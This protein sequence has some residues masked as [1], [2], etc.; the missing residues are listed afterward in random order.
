MSVL[1]QGRESHGRQVCWLPMDRIVPNPHQ[2][3][4]GF[5]DFSLLELASSIRQHGLLQ[6][7][8]VREKAG[9]YEIIMGERRFRAC[10]LLGYTH[11]DAF[12]LAADRDESAVLAL[13]ENIQRE[14]LHY[15]EE[16]EAYADLL[17]QGMTQD[18]LAR[19]L[20]K[21]PSG[22]ANKLRLLK[23]DEKLRHFLFEEGLSERHARAL[24][25]LP[26]AA[27]RW[28]IARQAEAQRLTVR[29]TETLVLR[30]QKRLPVPPPGRK[31]IS[32]VRDHRLYINAIKSV[33][34]QMQDTGLEA[35]MDLDE[36]E[37][38]AEMRI[39]MGR[40]K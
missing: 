3:R 5:D 27:A 4:K 24:L 38:W 23:L 1:Q 30:A 14:N 12:V 39:R 29:E 11:I 28:R 22:V 36:G 9:Q 40:K 20:G 8:T 13:I 35:E 17:A 19:R 26:D 15:F 2:P 7:I 31:V 6:P 25:A 34:A 32:L 37:G 16:A 10:R 33:V 18:A 21:S